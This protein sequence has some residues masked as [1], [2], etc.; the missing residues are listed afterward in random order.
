MGFCYALKFEVDDL[1]EA[2]DFAKKD[3]LGS[4]NDEN[5][6]VEEIGKKELKAVD[7]GQANNALLA[8]TLIVA[9]IKK[10]IDQE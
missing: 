1:D 8:H 10:K 3:P 7:L 5:E 9:E 6:N 4:D 2:W